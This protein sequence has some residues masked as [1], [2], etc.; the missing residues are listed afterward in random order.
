MSLVVE[1]LKKTFDKQEVLKGISFTA[2][3]G[4][5]CGFL[6]PNGAGK[7]TTMK[8]ATGFYTPQ[9]GKIW[10]CGIDMSENS[11]EG[12][13]KIG[14]LPEQNPLYPEMY[15]KEYLNFAGSLCKMD[16]EFKSV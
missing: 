16:K 4:E 13:C 11:L 6:G 10:V 3:K 15:V 5:I 12:R 14:Y 1:N 9:E 7:S 2:N 8:L